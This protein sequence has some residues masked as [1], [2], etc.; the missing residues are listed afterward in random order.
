MTRSIAFG[1]FTCVLLGGCS[2]TVTRSNAVDPVLAAYIPPDTVVL[3]AMRVD[4]LRDTP[5]YRKL[6][7]QK[8]LPNLSEFRAEDVHD[9]LLA[10]DAKNVLA[11]GRGTFPAHSDAIT[12][13]D[14]HTALAGPPDMV[15]AAIQRARSGSHSPPRD[16][17]A[18]AAAVPGNSQ[19]WAVVADWP[20]LDPEMLRYMGNFGNIDRVLRSVKGATL[21]IDLSSG[22]HTIFTGDCQTEADAGSLADSL[23]GLASLARIAVAQ[24]QPD[25]ARVFDGLQVRQDGR[26]VTLSIDVPESL[27]EQLADKIG[28]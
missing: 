27:A 8:R 4:Q 22:A 18:R 14:R 19:I 23:R 11:I 3:A 6:S 16:L 9:V 13:A 7:A 25:L 5:L 1:L 24:K 12:L 20:G 26:I 15:Q 2:S 21:T 28:R 17:M 10:S